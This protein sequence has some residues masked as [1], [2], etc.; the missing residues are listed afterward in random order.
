MLHANFVKNSAI[1]RFQAQ[2]QCLCT[3]RV[4]GVS[5]QA[6]RVSLT[7]LSRTVHQNRLPTHFKE[8]KT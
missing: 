4:P 8:K 3:S 6:A 7:V 2:G 5:R 1:D